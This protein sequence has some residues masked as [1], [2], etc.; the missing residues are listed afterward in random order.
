MKNPH[1]HNGALIIITQVRPQEKLSQLVTKQEK[2]SQLVTKM[3]ESSRKLVGKEEGEESL[4]R[5]VWAECKWMWVVAAPAIF[6]RASTFGINVTSQAFVG[7]IGSK[8]LAAYALVFTVLI[9]FAN[10]ILVY[11]YIHMLFLLH[12]PSLSLNHFLHCSLQ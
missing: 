2:L 12:L 7:H 1:I 10:G 9:R 5:R 8:E 11:I 3:E 6:T 4:V